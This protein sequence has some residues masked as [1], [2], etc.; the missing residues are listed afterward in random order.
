MAYEVLEVLKVL[1]GKQ[2]FQ[3]ETSRSSTSALPSLSFFFCFVRCPLSYS[4]LGS[5]LLEPHNS[6]ECA[7]NQHIYKDALFG[8]RSSDAETLAPAFEKIQ[9]FGHPLNRKFSR[10]RNSPSFH[11]PH[12][13]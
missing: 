2:T 9:I 6:T 10:S 1:N 12:A 13:E 8:D 7:G 4:L 3:C 11:S 5:L